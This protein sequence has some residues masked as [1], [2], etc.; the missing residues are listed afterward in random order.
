M[1]DPSD[2]KGTAIIVIVSMAATTELA[3]NIR[4]IETEIKAMASTRDASSPATA[5]WP[6]RSL[7]E[8]VA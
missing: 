3:A 4:K 6:V 2:R 7:R 1:H 8:D 5:I